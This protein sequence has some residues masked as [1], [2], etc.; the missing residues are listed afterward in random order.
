MKINNA[1]TLYLKELTVLN[2]AADTIRSI[3]L[4]LNPLLRFLHD[5]NIDDIEQLTADVLADYQQELSFKIT[6]KGTPLT[7]GSQI[8]RLCAARG[9]TRFLK[10]KDYLAGDPGSKIRLPKTVKRLPKV[11]LS[12]KEVKTLVQAQDMRTRNGYR[13]RLIIEILYDTGIRRGELA[14]VRTTDIDHNAGY[15]HIRNGK[16]GKDRVVPVGDR[17]CKLIHNYMLFIR[18]TFVRDKD[19]G[20]L[21]LNQYGANMG[22][23]GIYVQVCQAAEKAGIKKK[24]TTHTL[25]HSCATH[26]LKNGAP[27][28]HIQELLGH[29]CLDS[30]Q[31]Y[32]RVTINDLKQ[33]HTKYHPGEKMT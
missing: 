6:A 33:I 3:K 16:G 4:C 25:R 17:V 5:Q 2:R 29:Q 30:T 23:H 1:I 32:T 27:L 22:A 28:R 21:I 8:R 14:G 31:I 11:I 15:L 7:I 13:R 18:P 12:Q 24:I 9:L 19:P 26:M 10:D 20:N